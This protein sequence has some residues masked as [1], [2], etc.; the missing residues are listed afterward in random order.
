M[1]SAFAVCG[2]E[3]EGVGARKSRSKMF[4]EGAEACVGAVTEGEVLVAATAGAA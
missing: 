3:A 4:E 2:F 1:I